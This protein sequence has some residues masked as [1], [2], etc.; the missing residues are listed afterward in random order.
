MTYINTQKLT[1]LLVLGALSFLLYASSAL[2]VGVKPLR[3]E[4]TID[5]GSSATATIKVINSENKQVTVKPEIDVYVANDLDGYPENIDLEENDPRNIEKWIQFGEEEITLEANSEKETTFTVTVPEGAEPGGRYA[6]IL[7]EPV[8]EDTE[9]VQVRSRVASLILIQVTGEEILTGELDEFSLYEDKLYSDQA[10]T[11]AVNFK[12]TGNIHSKP[13]GEIALYNESGEKLEEVA[14][15]KDPETGKEVVA[16]EIPVNINGGNVLPGSARVFR[17]TWSE[18]IAEGKY[19]AKLNLAY[20]NEEDMLTSE[21]DF[22]TSSDLSV[23]S[24]KLMTENGSAYFAIEFKNSGKVYEKPVGAIEVFN[25]YNAPVV[26]IDL[27][28]DMEYVVPG[29]SETVK[30]D[31]LEGKEVPEG[32]YTA[33]LALKYGLTGEELTSEATFTG[34]EAAG[35]AKSFLQTPKGMAVAGLAVLILL[36]VV[37]YAGRSKK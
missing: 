4:L 15:Y 21:L 28:E 2:A 5:P 34:A 24:F 12:N 3:T 17:P 14:R 37:Y 36:V 8:V 31:W 26:K 9:G 33:K 20:G 18:N 6:S 7:Y 22:D 32:E 19:T 13:V 16:D 27:P 29:S 30:I 35:T 10:V 11:L 23:E 1:K 25:E